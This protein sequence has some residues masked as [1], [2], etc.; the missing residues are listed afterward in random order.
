MVSHRIGLIIVVEAVVGTAEAAEA[1]AAATEAGEAIAS[2]V[3]AGE[4]IAT[5]TEAGTEAG[6]EAG[7]EAGTAASEGGESL[8]KALETLAAGLKKVAKMVGEYIIIDQVFKAA[9]TILKALT[10]DPAAQ[11]CARKLAALVDVLTQT[12]NVMEKVNNWMQAHAKDTT[13]LQGIEVLVDQGVLAKFLSPLGAVSYRS[14]N[15]I[16]EYLHL[17]C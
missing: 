3:E 13:K 17:P 4:A 10:T 1:A 7:A 8:A 5:G 16:L 14:G 2:G 9:K 12:I 11:E 15:I 6:A